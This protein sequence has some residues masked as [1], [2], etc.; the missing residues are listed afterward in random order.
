M[1]LLKM[2]LGQ[3]RVVIVK[4]FVP[5]MEYVRVAKNRKKCTETVV[6]SSHYRSY[7]RIIHGWRWKL[8]RAFR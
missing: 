2:I 1:N 8:K 5:E 7:P 3:D 4:R 6:R